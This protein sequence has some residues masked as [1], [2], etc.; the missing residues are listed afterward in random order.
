MVE[1]VKAM[2]KLLISGPD[3]HLKKTIF[4]FLGHLCRNSGN[5]FRVAEI[6]LVPVRFYSF[7]FHFS[8]VVSDR[9]DIWK[10]NVFFLNLAFIVIKLRDNFSF[11]FRFK[12][13]GNVKPFVKMSQL[14]YFRL[15]WNFARRVE[16]FISTV[17]WLCF[18]KI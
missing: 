3:K 12:T 1:K 7:F 9:V 5:D 13:Y 15:S 6:A 4:Y 16:S 11:Y 17:V 10:I 14:F 8:S 18:F 2:K